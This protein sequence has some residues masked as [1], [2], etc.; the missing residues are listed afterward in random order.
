VSAA[1]AAV[2]RLGARSRL[3]LLVAT[4]T[5]VWG[6]LASL[7]RTPWIFADELIYTDLARSLASGSEPSVRG[8]VTY[9][10]GLVY[11]LLIA[12]AWL[13]ASSAPVAFA[14]IRVQDA[15][16]MS[17]AAIPVFLLARRLVAERNAFLVAALSVAIPSMAYAATLMSEVAFYPAFAL[18]LWCMAR[19][20]DRPTPGSQSA[21]LGAIGIAAAC[22]VLA[23]ALV[24][25]LAAGVVLLAVLDRV[26]DRTSIRS[27]LARFRL[28]WVVLGGGVLAVAGVALVRGSSPLGA[29]GAY[30]EAV[31]SVDVGSLLLAIVRH[32]AA[33][34]LYS[35][36]A[37]LAATTVVVALALGRDAD[38][39][40]RVFA[41]LALPTVLCTTVGVA[42]FASFA[43][44]VDYQATGIPESAPV[45]ERNLF[46]VVPLLLLGLALWVERGLP[47]PRPLAPLAA[48]ACV[49]LLAVYPWS[50]LPRAANPQNL[51]ATVWL[52]VQPTWLVPVVACA[53]AV[54]VAVLW[55][56]IEP[57]RAGRLW[58]AVA[59]W[60][61]FA[62]LLT[63][64]VFTAISSNTGRTGAGAR[65]DWIDRAVGREE[66]VLLLWSEPDIRRYAEPTDRQ[67]IVWLA[68]LYNESVGE[69]HVLGARLP[70]GLGGDVARLASDGS[71]VDAGGLRLRAPFVLAECSL[72]VVGAAVAVDR[73]THMALYRTTDGVRVERGARRTDAC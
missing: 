7:S 49:L 1:A 15:L 31:R 61:A 55:L 40:G 62:G 38:R 24:P 46:V 34:S 68:E 28:T 67:R 48:A 47:R 2:G 19:A 21:A 69:V 50:L 72:G 52:L 30:E 64:I 66:H 12:P 57:D 13:L 25:A 65:P 22:K 36:V 3:A 14:L 26:S 70:Y 42:V 11:P 39:E 71:V 9:G 8:V 6:A 33:L 35:A 4:A 56:R 63:V 59:S 51:A 58:V 54:V 73:K 5:L 29:F 37:P 17:L 27:S 60:F 41:A 53:F 32:L 43:S 23:V 44:N 16:L 20:L 45:Y 10:Y 18:A